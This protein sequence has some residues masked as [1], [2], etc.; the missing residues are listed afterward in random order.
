MPLFQEVFLSEILRFF[1]DRLNDLWHSIPVKSHGRVGSLPSF[2]RTFTQHY[3]IL[4]PQ[5]RL[6]I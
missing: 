6:N 5:M 4:T 1:I 3:D 2:N